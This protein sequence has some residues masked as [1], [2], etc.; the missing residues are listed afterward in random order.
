MVYK[1]IFFNILIMFLSGCISKDKHLTNADAHSQKSSELSY[2]MR[3]LYSVIDDEHKSELE[4]DDV[5]RRYALR[6][7][8]KIKEFSYQAR[9][10]SEEK[11]GKH[12]N[13]NNLDAFGKNIQAL[14]DKGKEIADISNSYELERL[15]AKLV[16]LK[17][18]CNSC[19][20]GLG[21]KNENLFN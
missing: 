7:S 13:E 11:L 3:E 8:D 5:R 6:L 17:N 12:V 9:L 19:H 14:Q 16:E 1:I 20:I 4:R 21:V 10:L 18:I 15:D 2:L